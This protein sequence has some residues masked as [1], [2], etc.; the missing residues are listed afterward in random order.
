MKRLITVIA[1]AGLMAPAG[2]WARG[3][4]EALP[5]TEGV[6]ISGLKLDGRIEGENITF[7]L[8]FTAEL[9]QDAVSLPLL[10]GDVAYLEGDLPSNSELIRG[11]D[12]YIL[13]MKRKGGFWSF[14]SGKRT[15]EFKFAGRAAREGDWRSASFSIPG[16]DIR[17]VSILCDRDDLEIRFPGALN[18][19][20]VKTDKGDMEVTAFLGL[21]GS[22]NV[23]WKPEVKKLAADLVVACDA[24][25][26]ASASVGALKIDNV[27]TYRVVQGSLKEIPLRLPEELSVTQVRGEDIQ[28]WVIQEKEGEAARTLLVTLSRPKEKD[29][30]L[31]VE[32]ETV[33]PKFPCELELPVIIPRRVIRSSGFLMLG[34]DSA[35]KLLVDKALGLTQVDQTSFP[36]VALEGKK[37]SGRTL[38]S[39][40]RFAYQYANVPY[41]LK[42]SIDDIVSEYSSNEQLVLSVKDS[43]LVLAASVEL[44]VRDAPA[45]EIVIETDPDW[46]VANVSGAAL[47]DYN[48]RTRNGK[49]EISVFF[50]DAVTGRTLVNVRLEKSLPGDKTRFQAPAF[51][52]RDSESQRGYL[53]LS[54]EKGLRIEKCETGKLREVQT[55][56][57]PVKVPGAQLAYRY[58]EGEWSLDVK[59]ERTKPTIH[60][61]LFHLVSIGE[62]VLYCSSAATYHIAGAPVKTFRIRI[63]EE[64]QNVEFTGRDVRGWKH[65]GEV[66]EISLQE[67]VMGDYTL[68]VT[69]DRKFAYR[70]DE[71]TV[72]GVSTVETTTETGYIMLAGAAA[73]NLTLQERDKSIIKVDRD[74]VPEAYTLLVNDP[75]LDAYKYTGHP[76]TAK[77]GIKRYETERLLDAVVDLTMLSTRISKDGEAVTTAEYSVKNLSRQYLIV[78]I[79]EEANLWS[80]SLINANEE[81]TEVTALK[82][83]G[84]ILIPVRRLRNPNEPVRVEVVYA[85]SR[86][87]IGAL[88]KSMR[89]LAPVTGNTPNTFAKWEFFLPEGYTVGTAGGNM[90]RAMSIWTGGIVEALRNMLKL[91][92]I[93]L[94][95]FAGWTVVALAAVLF[96]CLVAFNTGRGRGFGWQGALGVVALITVLFAGGL[97]QLG[98]MWSGLERTVDV[99]RGPAAGSSF[100]VSRTVNL[101]GAE[102]L[103]V[104]LRLVPEWIGADSSLLWAVVAV[105]LSLWLILK[106][107]SGRKRRAWCTALGFTLLT[108]GLAQLETGRNLITIMFAVGVAVA[109]VLRLVKAAYAAGTR[110]PVPAGPAP[111]GPPEMPSEEAP[112]DGMPFEEETEDTVEPDRFDEPEEPDR[113]QQGHGTISCLVAIGIIGASLGWAAG[114][115]LDKA[116]TDVLPAMKEVNIQVKAP[117]MTE[118]AEKSARVDAVYEFEGR[119]GSEFVVLR[120]PAVLTDY[121]LNSSALQ[122]RTDVNGYVLTVEE[123]GDYEI[124]LKYSLPLVEKEGAWFLGLRIPPNLK[125]RVKLEIPE[126]ELEVESPDAVLFKTTEK[127]DV[128]EAIAV[129]G[130]SRQAFISW[131]PRARKT[132]LEKV[133]FFSELNTM[134]VF[135]P[136]V[137][138]LT[139]LVKYQIAQGELKSMN[140]EVPENMTVTAVKAPGLSTWRF[141]PETRLL[142]AIVDK[143][144]TGDFTLH[145]VS[146][147][148]C[149]GLPYKVQAGILKVKDAVRQRGSMALA[150]PGNVKILVSETEGLHPMNIEDVSERLVREVGT[151]ARMKEVPEIKRAFRYHKTPASGKVTAERVLPELRVAENGSMSVS[152]E[153]IV[154]STHLK[155]GISKAGIFSVRLGIPDEYDVES[156]TGQDVSHWDEVGG[157]ADG[158]TP[159]E[160]IVHFRKKALGDRT[161]NVVAARTEKGL[162]ETIYV[163]RIAVQDALKHTGQMVVR[164]ER[165]VRMSTVMRKG[166]SEMNP[167]DLGIRETGALAFKL[168]RPEWMIQL[169]A[170]TV[171]PTIRTEVL[172]RVDLSEGKMRGTAY[173]RYRI[174]HAGCKTF[175]LKAPAPGISLAMTGRDIAKVHEADRE[176]GIWEVELHNKVL[177]DYQLEARYQTTQAGKIRAIVPLDVESRKGYLAVMSEGRA[178]VRPAGTPA[179]LKRED[180]RSVPGYFGAGDL[181][182]AVY[183]FRT[184]GGEYELDLSVI[185]HGAAEVLPAEVS[186]TRLTS[187]VSGQGDILTRVSMEMTVGDLRFLEIE[188]PE[189]GSELWSAFVNGKA[190][191]VSE[192]GGVYRIPLE[193]P[194]PGEKTEVEMVYVSPSPG[195]WYSSRLS[196]KAPKFGLPLKKDIEWTFY[197]VPGRLYYGF[198]G[199]MNPVE[200]KEP[201]LQAF[202]RQQYNISNLRKIAEEQEKAKSVLAKGEKYAQQGQQKLAR[203][204][205]ESAVNWSQNDLAFNEDARIQ[206]RN[207]AKQQ[208]LVGLVQRRD[209]MRF[210]KN[211]QQAG[212]V[213]RIEDFRQGNFTAEYANRIQQ[214]LSER[215]NTSLLKLSERIMDQQAAAERSAQA[216]KI[217]IPTHGRKLMFRRS[218]QTDPEADMV[219]SFKMSGGRML[220]WGAG[221]LIALVLTVAYRALS[222]RKY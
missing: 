45:R 170:E 164:G 121:D 37:Q 12:R 215:D 178:E 165:G 109:V 195:K 198:G 145:V 118:E 119:K 158:R 185:R 114:E 42:L 196:Y 102:P 116:E 115:P 208:A 23:K 49:R 64:F 21:A 68:G 4:K 184:I 183:C 60:S 11:S 30:M 173:V 134:A 154:L 132:R 140:V 84:R 205:L 46:I 212:Q 16:A 103:A 97:W 31:R 199:T 78:S 112:L 54:V 166:V 174:E 117:E 36:E 209:K 155:V 131:R 160:V 182:D 50:R 94:T 62:G 87:E 221:L 133:V 218:M 14:D 53:V 217:T 130:M 74:E 142:E 67:K 201:V 206:F 222:T 156:L 38:P 194:V 40:S 10:I 186:S 98:R 143:P 189:E 51:V 44:D 191:S 41:T 171:E 107:R 161:L 159:R 179:G 93:A 55:G 9:E 210:D 135:Q 100:S 15:V 47:S 65:D 111:A 125:N 28:D 108:F 59:F 52:I 27:F 95:D 79:P 91:Y 57:V 175:R 169:K 69:Y 32:S 167:R 25:T 13:K 136:G 71:V 18:V 20:R 17:K 58:K 73:L 101:E 197:V 138:E 168:L 123:R 22:F 157:E 70:A 35:I 99:F 82:E 172:H 141:D 219:V 200:D 110:R 153:R 187:V 76:H 77:I 24:N 86:D 193:E 163:P 43:D 89:F 104:D 214:S 202:T 122:L 26:I 147:V 6:E 19:E 85:R 2:A 7:T 5:R 66:W 151:A 90:S 203:K 88:G 105:V 80:T 180:S 152:D 8:S 81:K 181:S 1:L 204:A 106:G 61:E 63:P 124:N 190:A 126:N 3:Q 146:Q 150:V 216:I 139:N 72:G 162:E 188:L 176:K 127:E 192:E 211:I 207:L 83:D 56:S 148:G 129:Y 113:H 137:V 120:P 177:N 39:R 34:T 96:T 128:T 75:I 48:V 220:R 149:E 29:Y 33:L 213:A 92:G 144:V